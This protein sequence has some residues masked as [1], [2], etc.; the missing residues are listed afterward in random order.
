MKILQHVLV[1]SSTE[2]KSVLFS[3]QLSQVWL[4]NKPDVSYKTS[5]YDT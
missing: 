2:K 5:T 3:T 4:Q 1:H